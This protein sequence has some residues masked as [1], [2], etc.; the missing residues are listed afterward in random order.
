MVNE[1]QKAEIY[2]QLA[3]ENLNEENYDTALAFYIKSAEQS[4]KYIDTS[5]YY[6]MSGYG[7]AGYI[8][9]DQAQYVK[10]LKMLNLALK[11]ALLENDKVEIAADYTNLGNTYIKMGDY[12]KASYYFENSLKI[13]LESGNLSYLSIDYNSLGKLYELWRRYDVSLEY[14]K[15]ALDLDEKENNKEKIA[16]RLNS[17]G[18]NFRNLGQFDSA[19]FYITRA[20]KIDMELGDEE[21]IAI[22]YSNLGSIYTLTK[23]YQKATHFYLKAIELFE[24]H[25]INYSLCITYNEY[26]ALLFEKKQYAESVLYSKKSAI[27]AKK[28][29]YNLMLLQNYHRLSQLYEIQKQYEPA[30]ENYKQYTTIKDSIFSEKSMQ[31]INRLEIK[32]E[33]EKLENENINLK[34]ESAIKDLILERRKLLLLAFVIVAGLVIILTIILYSRIRLKNKTNQILSDK[35]HELEILN[36]TKDKFFGIISHDLRNPLSAFKNVTASLESNLD[37]ISRNEMKYFVSEL[38]DSS[39]RLYE[40]LQSLLIWSQTQSSN[41][42]CKLKELNLLEAVK[43]TI[44]LFE[45]NLHEKN[46][47]VQIEINDE[48]VVSADEEML[49]TILRNLISNAIKFTS[50]NGFIKIFSEN[51]DNEII[52]S[53]EDSGIGMSKSD[54]D[55]LFKINTDVKTI[56]NSMEKGAGLGLIICK[57][58]LDKCGGKIFAESEPNR[59]TC[60]KFTLS[61]VY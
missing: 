48:L 43:N 40:L 49:Q 19:V 53:I 33:T 32:Y 17:I 4:L 56:G 29:K 54:I 59:G 5:Y 2:Y 36:A 13:D 21:R 38:S 52:V 18:V 11:Y 16:I 45:L 57:E 55:K 35:N 14:F 37:E 27:I 7:N 41:V 61:K 44:A 39:S 1:G 25:N 58:M 60:F 8:L 12:E 26:A 10:A 6:V 46:L 20:L 47:E 15:K 9:N 22:R 23:D 50:E 31:S 34:N 28:I 30:L 51:V 3:E 42:K 24:K